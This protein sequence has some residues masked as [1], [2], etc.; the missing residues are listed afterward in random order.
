MPHVSCKNLKPADI[1]KQI[2]EVSGVTLLTTEDKQKCP[3]VSYEDE[4]IGFIL[5]VSR[6]ANRCPQVPTGVESQAC[7]SEM[8]S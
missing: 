2:L 5:I 6:G 4:W 1:N 8:E 3:A 7:N